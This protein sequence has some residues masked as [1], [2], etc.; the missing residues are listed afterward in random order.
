MSKVVDTVNEVLRNMP[1]RRTL[2]SH[3]QYKENAFCGVYAFEHGDNEAIVFVDL[4][5]TA[6]PSEPHSYEPC[7]GYG[8]VKRL[9]ASFT[10]GADEV[11][12]VGEAVAVVMSR[13]D[14]AFKNLKVQERQEELV[15][16]N[17][18]TLTASP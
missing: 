5:A 16:T 11:K 9:G 13:F 10:V 12:T 3:P 8:C 2:K 6:D 17:P 14:E 15:W 1:T 7:E 4:L 18:V